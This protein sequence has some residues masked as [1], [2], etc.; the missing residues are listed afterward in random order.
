MANRRRLGF[1]GGILEIVGGARITLAL[2]GDVQTVN[3]AN[4]KGTISYWLVHLMDLPLGWAIGFCVVGA[5][6]LWW[7]FNFWPF[8]GAVPSSEKET[9]RA[10]SGHHIINQG[11]NSTIVVSA[12]AAPAQP[13]DRIFVSPAVTSVYLQKFYLGKHTILEADALAAPFLGKWMMVT[14]TFRDV[15]SGWRDLQ[16][17]MR[18]LREP[19]LV[20][21]ESWRERL[22][23]L[24]KGDRITVCGKISSIS[25]LG[26]TLKNCE[27]LD[28]QR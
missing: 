8:G 16:V 15:K 4:S 18:F 23:V 24:R 20:F 22:N 14:G 12:P 26:V 7:A 6:A 5:F 13:S 25:M 17:Y 3:D 21:E 2:I 1:V 28:V 11:D 9:A 27:L 10:S 19:L